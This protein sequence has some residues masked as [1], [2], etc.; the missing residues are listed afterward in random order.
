MTIRTRFAPSPTGY[1]HIG[2]VRTAFFNW[3]YARRH[4]G[5][6]VLRIDDTDTERNVGEALQPILDGFRWLGLNWDEGPGIDGPYAPY[7]QSQR[8]DKYHA[9]I[10]QL[11]DA[12]HLYPSY[13]TKEELDAAR[14]SAEA[15][16]RNFVFRGEHR[17]TSAAECRKLYE[18]N[19][20]VLRLKVPEN[21]KVQ[22]TDMIRGSVEWD[23]NLIGDPVLIRADGSPLYNFA[24]VVDD[25]DLQITHVIRAAEHLT[26]T[27]V[28]VLI[29]EAMGYDTPQFAHVPVVN[30]PNS[31]KKLS[32]RK[33]AK[34]LT[35]EVREKLRMIGWTDAEID[36]RDDLNPATIAYYRELGYLP[37]AVLNYLGRL[38]WS[39]DDHSEIIPL[40]QMIANFS[41]ERVNDSPASFDPE[42]MLWVAGEYMKQLPI[43]D[44]VA[45]VIP[46]L[47]RVGLVPEQ[48][49]AELSQK[50][51]MIVEATGERLKVFSDILVHAPM[52]LQPEI[53]YDEKALEKKLGKEHAAD[54]LKSYRDELA[55]TDDFS[56]THLEQLLV[57]VCE[58]HG[59]KK[60]LLIHALRLAVTGKE[61]GLG[62]YETLVILGKSE[63]IKRI[64]G[65]F[66]VLA[67]QG[68]LASNSAAK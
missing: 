61:V 31:N 10:Q 33:M 3:L 51:T 21:R 63:C 34:F 26:N 32:K 60:N 40:P 49:S 16:K 38:G 54:L 22:I 65:C 11:L 14:K 37:G 68:I 57:D 43:A 67:K 48:V 1:L 44:K 58:K 4:E 6:F 5:K 24:S 12:G 18:A 28:Q 52:F 53:T 55:Q 64:D 20:T 17:N 2:G 56:P 47:Q 45:G 8:S 39:L 41:F 29:Y 35:P 50:I 66:V 9:A 42:K 36:S 15:E 13:E 19:A 7:F 59:Q 30:E 62:L 46:F 23:T 27:A 25:V